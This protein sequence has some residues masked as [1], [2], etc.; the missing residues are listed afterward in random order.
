MRGPDILGSLEVAPIFGRIAGR[1]PLARQSYLRHDALNGAVA[2]SRADGAA[3]FRTLLR[4]RQLLQ[5]L[6]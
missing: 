2:I 4:S 3:T 5:T 6:A 1:R